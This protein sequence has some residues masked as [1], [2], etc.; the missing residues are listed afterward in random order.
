MIFFICFYWLGVDLCIF[1]LF[2]MLFCFSLWYFEF[3]VFLHVWPLSVAG[4]ESGRY[5]WT[6][7]SMNPGHVENCLLLI[8]FSTV[9]CWTECQLVEVFDECGF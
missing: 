5:F 2:L 3:L 6:A 9:F 4:T 7:R 1:Q 8:A